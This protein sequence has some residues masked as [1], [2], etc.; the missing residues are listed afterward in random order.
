MLNR[1]CIVAFMSFL[2]A[3]CDK[4]TAT[5]TDS[6]LSSSSSGIAQGTSLS[7]VSASVVSEILQDIANLSVENCFTLNRKAGINFTN[8]SVYYESISYY[9]LPTGDFLSMGKMDT[10]P[11]PTTDDGLI[12][13][14]GIT[15]SSSFLGSCDTSVLITITPIDGY[16][17]VGDIYQQGF[18]QTSYYKAGT[19][20]P[21]LSVDTVKD[22]S[23][24][25][26]KYKYGGSVFSPADL[27]GVV[28]NRRLYE[29]HHSEAGGCSFNRPCVIG[30]VTEGY[31]LEGYG[32]VYLKEMAY[33][34]YEYYVADPTIQAQVCEVLLS[35][36][37]N[38]SFCN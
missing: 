24:A 21:V 31:L 4:S 30:P 1:T 7:S 35:T 28:G 20:A 8:Y 10:L 5:G 37:G 14:L 32:F 38:A 2:L 25:F 17:A 19:Q 23:L 6:D 15:D 29:T 12:S 33:G 13:I 16:V 27:V 36:N 9:L 18:I 26:N 3:G 22:I 11:K 34:N